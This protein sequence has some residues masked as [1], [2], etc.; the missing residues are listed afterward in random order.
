MNIDKLTE[1]LECSLHG[2]FEQGWKLVQELEKERPGCNRC[3]FNRGW[4]VLRLGQLNRGME[5][6][7][8]GRFEHVFGSPH[9][10]TPKPIYDGR[11]LLNN[12]FVVLHLEGGLGDEMIGV[13]FAKEIV[14]LGGRCV[15][16]CHPSLM[17][18]FSRVEGVTAIVNSKAASLT[19]HEFWV[20]AMSAE[21]AMGYEYDTLPNKPYIRADEKY[22]TKFKEIINTNKFKIGIRYVGNPMF[23]HEQH[24]LF[25]EELMFNL[26]T[27]LED[28]IQVYSLQKDLADKKKLPNNIIDLEPH[29]KT[30]EDTAGAIENLD[31]V[32]SSCTSI[33]HLSAAMGKMT[34]IVVPILSYYVWAYQLEKDLIS[35]GEFTSY[36]KSVRL[37][38][39]TEY[40]T[41]NEPFENVKKGL[42]NIL[43]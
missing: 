25:P 7:S 9:I 26:F 6:I 30:W 41:W 4:Y 31:L 35:Q 8:R 2:D 43:R 37:F 21:Y 24:R 23:E 19:Y 15:L 38:R 16:S 32:I 5:L 39:Q 28:K 18:L 17:S 14:K 27:G 34:F 13:R 36:Y 1:Q 22:V 12:E 20:P 42:E 40:G 10:G 3:A 33:A 11:K 29:L